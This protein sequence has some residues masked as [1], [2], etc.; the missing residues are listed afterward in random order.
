MEKKMH[1]YLDRKYDLYKNNEKLKYQDSNI[2]AN[3]ANAI[4]KIKEKEI[5]AERRKIWRELG[6]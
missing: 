5:E 4:L 2:D 1:S 6:L 3:E